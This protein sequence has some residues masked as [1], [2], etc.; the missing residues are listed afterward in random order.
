[1][2]RESFER[3]AVKYLAGRLAERRCQ[4]GSAPGWIR[5]RTKEE[6][7]AF[8]EAG[9][10]VVSAAFGA[11]VAVTVIPNER[12]GYAGRCVTYP[13]GAG[14]LGIRRTS[15]DVAATVAATASRSAEP[16]ADE[17][18]AGTVADM[19][20]ALFFAALLA[21]GGGWRSML[22]ELRRLRKTAQNL[23][24]ANWQIVDALAH[25]LIERR[26]LTAEEFE[27]F[28]APYRRPEARTEAA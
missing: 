6:L 22:A 12:L 15:S 8:H 4:R 24:E 27:A 25:V 3:Q 14:Q 2:P 1:M 18:P 21:Q 17:T 26:A 16:T 13:A 20:A 19:K 28:I 11:D 10:A 7:L 9:H 5:P 23:L